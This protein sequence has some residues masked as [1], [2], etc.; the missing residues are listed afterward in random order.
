MHSTPATDKRRWLGLALLCA[1]FFM[2]IL[3]VAIVNVALPSIQ[4]DLDFSQKNLQW[5]VSA[6]ALTFGGLLLL[7][8]RAA[9]LLGRRRVFVAG[10]SVFAL[11]SL[12][13]G[14]APSA[15]LLVVARALQGIG[16]AAMTPAALSILTTT[17][18]E[19]ADRN[20]ALGAWG[21]VG[22]S[23]GTIGLL[24]GG[25]LADTLGWEWI[26]FLNV[27]IGAVVVALSP[28]LLDDTRAV[29]VPRRFDVAGAVTVTSALALLVYAL[30]GAS[31]AGWASLQTMGLMAVAAVLLAAFGVIESRSA[32]PLVPFRIFRLPALLASNVS[33][34]LFGAAVFGMFFVV[35]LYLQQVLGYSPL[36]AG[37]A[38]LA[39]SLTALAASVGG[40]VLVTRTGTRLPLVTGLAVSAAGLWLL[41]RVPADA[42]YS[43]D[44]LPALLVSGVGVGLTFVTMSIGGLEGVGERDSGLASGL[45]N[46]TQQIGGALGVAVLSAVA[47]SR[48]GDVL[49]AHPKVAPA[50]ALAEGFG[51]ALLVGAGFA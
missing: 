45:V 48:S 39:L 38:W 33:G 3:D 50:A 4:G 49:A 18:R 16:A 47:L 12:L 25:V 27:P 43:H 42:S 40:A 21:A 11:A 29:G 44:V 8:G 17:F 51:D 37:F 46:T 9:D 34:V 2:V 13:A 10:V 1:A 32:A 41:S 23:G 6:Y 36:H 31:A 19:G 7:G 14:L 30:V 26:F 28:L 35:T 5:V 22:S 15:A 24:L 20:K